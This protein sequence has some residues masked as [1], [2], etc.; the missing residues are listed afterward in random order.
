ML[1]CPT[2][3]CLRC[4]ES[5]VGAG[6]G[7]S[8]VLQ[9]A[10][11]ILHL[12]G[13]TQEQLWGWERGTRNCFASVL[14][15]NPITSNRISSS[16]KSSARLLPVPR[17]ENQTGFVLHTAPLT[18]STSSSSSTVGTPCPDTLICVIFRGKNGQECSNHPILGYVLLNIFQI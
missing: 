12:P 9:V 3:W 18:L 7:G 5:R 6:N 15:A 2:L 10:A 16:T 17:S 8:S 11:D 1:L 4:A 13:T 14:A